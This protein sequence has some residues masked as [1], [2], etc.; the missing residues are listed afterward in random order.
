MSSPKHS[1]NCLE[2]HLLV[3]KASQ[4]PLCLCQDKPEQGCCCINRKT[5]AKKGWTSE[6][7]S[8]KVHSL[9]AVKRLLATLNR[10]IIGGHH[11]SVSAD[12][13]HKVLH[14]IKSFKLSPSPA[15]EIACTVFSCSNMSSNA[16]WCFKDQ[17][18]VSLKLSLKKNVFPLS[19]LQSL[20]DKSMI[21][22]APSFQ[23]KQEPT[24][25][26]SKIL[27]QIPPSAAP[28]LQRAGAQ[29]HNTWDIH[30]TVAAAGYVEM[31]KAQG[32]RQRPPTK[33][34]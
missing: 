27:R 16:L 32:C 28:E 19:T 2:V 23:P 33:R 3:T 17:L 5:F 34:W 7:V 1:S 12:G 24:C 25:K 10:G 18:D 11:I 9:K 22:S 21:L 4:K 20:Q 13:N 26:W 29:R 6:K 15:F 30:A 8:V 31:G 14:P